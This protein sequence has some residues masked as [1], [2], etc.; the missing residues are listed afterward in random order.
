MKDKMISPIIFLQSPCHKMTR[1]PLIQR[2]ADTTAIRYRI[3]WY[4]MSGRRVD[5]PWLNI[6]A[7]AFTAKRKTLRH[8]HESLVR[9]D[10]L[11]TCFT[12]DDSFTQ[13]AVAS[14]LTSFLNAHV[15][16]RS[17]LWKRHLRDP[18]FTLDDVCIRDDR[19]K[20][21][22][23]SRISPLFL[24]FCPDKSHILF[25]SN[26]LLFQFI[27]ETISSE[28]FPQFPFDDKLCIAIYVYLYTRFIFLAQN[29]ISRTICNADNSF[30]KM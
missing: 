6:N 7:R 5:R 15:V 2:E 22:E 3:G 13:Q 4:I 11:F 23:K 8:S 21:G 1:L 30:L 19:F 29:F 24:L 28:V 26:I 20:S 25:A 16:Q 14:L 17:H 18:L 12:F 9:W 10:S 27:R